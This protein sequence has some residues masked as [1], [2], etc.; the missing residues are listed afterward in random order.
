MNALR[1]ARAAQK[2]STRAR[3]VDAAI[4]LFAEKGYTGATIDEIT[5]RAG[6]TPTTLY[7]HFSSKVGLVPHVLERADPHFEQAYRE[8]TL[9]AAEPTPA[10]LRSW[11]NQMMTTWASVSPV[12]KGVY[13][14]AAVNAEV[15]AILTRAQDGQALALAGAL[16][17][18]A[19]ALSKPD[20]VVY[21]NIL[22]AP[23]TDYFGRFLRGEHFQRNRVVDALTASWMAVIELCRSRDRRPPGGSAR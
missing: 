4:E 22:L 23:L 2:E 19:P 3:L 18:A 17:A 15:R 16:R 6:S 14:A 1:T 7:L 11:L 13:E 12:M 21:A 9:I 10:A 20:A 5:E 8:L